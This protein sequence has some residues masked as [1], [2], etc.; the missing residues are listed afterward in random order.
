VPIICI[1]L[2]KYFIIETR[3]KIQELKKHFSENV[4]FTTNDVVAFYSN[5]ESDIP[6]STVNW[7]VYQLVRQGVLERV[8]KGKFRLGHSKLYSPEI[9]IR[10]FRLNKSIKERFPYISFCIW[11]Q[12]WINEFSQHIAKTGLV[13]IDVER[14]VAEAV[15]NYLRD[16]NSAIFYKPGKE[17]LN[18]FVIGLDYALLIRPLVS[19]APLQEICGVKTVTIEKLLVDAYTDL[20]FEFIQGMEIEH[21]FDNAFSRYSINITKLQR[22][23]DRKKRKDEIRKLIERF[24]PRNNVHP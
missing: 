24:T 11:Q 4:I 1:F 6:R 23:A 18:N 3:F 8:G 21:V 14:D 17:L 10:I 9:S 2:I 12:A 5:Y 7:R 22:Y 16:A 15:Y 13:F 20:E 19:E